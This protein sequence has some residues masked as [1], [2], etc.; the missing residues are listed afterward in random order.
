MN[1][2]LRR[3]VQ[4]LES[5]A[6]EARALSTRGSVHVRRRLE[7]TVD[8]VLSHLEADEQLRGDEPE[9]VISRLQRQ[10]QDIADDLRRVEE[11]MKRRT[12]QQ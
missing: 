11:L 3:A 6:E 7:Q 9:D 2:H 10:S 1:E 5:G 12:G 8:E 4:A